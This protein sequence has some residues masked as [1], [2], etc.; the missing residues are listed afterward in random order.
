MGF[1]TG[2]SGGQDSTQHLLSEVNLGGR[3]MGRI[4]GTTVKGDMSE[5]I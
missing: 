4:P 5:I 3:C 2:V 1:E